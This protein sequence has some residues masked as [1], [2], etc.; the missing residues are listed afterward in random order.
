[1]PGKKLLV[2]DDSL[3]IQKV[4]RLAL[5]NEGYEI[6]TVSDGQDAIQQILLFRPDAVLIDVSLP[7]KSAF[8]VKSSIEDIG[9]LP[10]C[11]FVLMSSAF[12]KFDEALAE[13]SQFH[14]RLTKPFDP[15]DLRKVIQNVLAQNVSPVSQEST[16]SSD[17]SGISLEIPMAPQF[18]TVSPAPPTE[19]PAHESFEPL[20]P[21]RSVSPLHDDSDIRELTESTLKMTGLDDFEWN[22]SESA[23]KSSPAAAQITPPPPPRL[24][25]ENTYSK[26]MYENEPSLMPPPSLFNGE[27]ESHGDSS[28]AASAYHSAPEHEPP[29]H[30]QQAPEA[31]ALP[32]TDAQMQEIIGRHVEAALEKMAKKM[33]P[34]IAERIIKEEIHKM[35]N[36]PAH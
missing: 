25:G 5:S 18:E 15:A 23:R 12:E 10:N 27:N 20:R 21:A 33:L 2:A 28:N 6:Q 14:G 17:H 13:R 30:S 3:T 8:E 24:L 19:F 9:S 34:D 32:V 31:S 7:E 22:V 1:M 35:L 11:R 16:Q 26:L 4:I 29:T 36:A